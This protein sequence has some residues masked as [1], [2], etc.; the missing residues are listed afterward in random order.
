MRG[1]RNLRI[2]VAALVV[3]IMV[4]TAGFHY[5]EGWP[6][7][8]SFYMV[9][10]TV[11]SIGYGEIHPLSNTGRI[12][13]SAVIVVGLLLLFLAIGS[14]TQ[15]LLEFELTD[16]F[17]RRKME[18]EI[19]KLS[20]HYII[21]G[22]GRV[23][24]SAAREL[25][26][27]PVPFVV[28]E[29]DLARVE[30]VGKNWLTLPGDATQEPVLRQAKIERAAGLVAA[31]TTDATNTYIVLT[32]RS[33]NPK[34]KIIARATSDDAQKHLLK[35]GADSVVSP[36]VFA[37]HRIAHSFL[38]PNVLDFLDT[39]TVRDG[40]MEMVIEEVL[41]GEGSKLDG[42]TVGS[43]GIHRDLGIIILAIKPKDRPARFNPVAQEPIRAGDY[44]IVMGELSQ[45]RALEAKAAPPVPQ[46]R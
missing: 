34:L 43:S 7:L 2:I 40:K 9:L 10:T 44:L 31:T 42:A 29:S 24:C 17:G 14:F 45:M 1:L 3:L 39:A 18:R 32:A 15:A 30:E 46:A 13:N 23:G 5:I 26:N 19:G 6:W 16:L 21:C 36:Y 28:I 27:R 25:A 22:A 8:D 11:T 37:G 41:V 12:F 4:G 35:A 38:R 33:L 20:G